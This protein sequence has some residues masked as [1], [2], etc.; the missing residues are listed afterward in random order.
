MSHPSTQPRYK[1]C[2]MPECSASM[3]GEYVKAKNSKGVWLYL[4]PACDRQR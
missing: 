3:R 2:T 1:P 4:C